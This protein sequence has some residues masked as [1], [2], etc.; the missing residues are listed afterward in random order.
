MSQGLRKIKTGASAKKPNLYYTTIAQNPFFGTRFMNTAI[1]RYPLKI[2]KEEFL[3]LAYR[4][5]FLSRKLE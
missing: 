1:P 3:P 4:W 2:K 5:M